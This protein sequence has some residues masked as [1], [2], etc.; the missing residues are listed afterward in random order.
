MMKT[1]LAILFVILLLCAAVAVVWRMENAQSVKSV[2]LKGTGETGRTSQPVRLQERPTPTPA[3]IPAF[4]S[5][6]GPFKLAPTLDPGMFTGSVRSAYMI[7]KEIPET[8]AQLPCYCKCD[9]SIG[10][11]SLHSCFVDDHASACGI[12]MNEAFEAY[13]LQKEQKLT[14]DKIREKIIADFSRNL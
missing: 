6:P 14:P 4:Q 7:A 2:A 3:P 9:K 11:K 10:H 5:G 8:L 1:I 12:C 13:R